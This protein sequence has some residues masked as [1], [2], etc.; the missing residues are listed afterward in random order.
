M[1]IRDRS[2]QPLKRTC[3]HSWH[4]AQ[5]GKMVPFAGYDMPVQ[6]KHGLMHE[7]NVVRNSA[8]IF[9]VSHMGQVRIFGKD[10][11]EF[12]ERATVIDLNTLSPG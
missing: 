5:G 8:G 1:C 12:I 9:D 10:R 11:D 6:Y 3:L 4:I 7:H 2:S